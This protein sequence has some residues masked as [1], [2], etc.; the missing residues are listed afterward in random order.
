MI[1]EFLNGFKKKCNKPE[2]D[3]TRIITIQ[4]TYINNDISMEEIIS[5][6]DADDAHVIKEK[7]F[8]LGD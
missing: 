8:I 4:A 2:Q 1:F 3:I 7:V 6:L 5:K